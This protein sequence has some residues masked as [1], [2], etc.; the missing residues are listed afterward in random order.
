MDSN[1]NSFGPYWTVDSNEVGLAVV[2]MALIILFPVFP[3]THLGWYIGE[4]FIGNNF[5]KWGL[6][7]LFFIIA[8]IYLYKVFEKSFWQAVIFV[9][10]EYLIY[11]IIITHMTGKN[12]LISV[13]IIKSILHWG[14]SNT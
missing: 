4:H 6:S 14:L 10:V 2:M 9:A 7:I 11:D 12:E 3:I 13:H 1:N 5:A 8:Y